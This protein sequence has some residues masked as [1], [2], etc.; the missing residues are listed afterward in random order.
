MLLACYSAYVTFMAYNR[1]IER[2]VK[3]ILNR[4]R[5]ASSFDLAYIMQVYNIFCG[6]HLFI[7][8]YLLVTRI[9]SGIWSVASLWVTTMDVR[10]AYCSFRQSSTHG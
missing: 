5:I 3:N 6:I 4:K 10:S 1:T 8:L 7:H 2:L 9:P